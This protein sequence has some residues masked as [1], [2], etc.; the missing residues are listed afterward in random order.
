[1]E[2]EIGTDEQGKPFADKVTAVGGNPIPPPDPS[3]KKKKPAAKPAEE[4]DGAAA[5][6][7]STGESGDEGAKKGRNRK[8]TPKKEAPPKKSDWY[9]ELD[10]AVQKSIEAKGIKID[11]G[12]VFISVGDARLKVG[13]GG[14]ITLA[15]ASGLVA[16]G[17]YTSDKNGK[18]SVT[19]EK[20][21]KLDGAEW[22]ASSVD[23]G[24][25]AL[26]KEIDLTTGTFKS[27]GVVGV[28]VS[29]VGAIFSSHVPCIDLVKPTGEEE[30]PESLWGEGKPDPKDVLEKEGFLMRKVS[31]TAAATPGRRARPRNRKRGPKKGGKGAEAAPTPA[32]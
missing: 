16:E 25:G 19:W 13:T 26:L 29:L 15:H 2:F 28:C 32:S 20:V 7:E 22:K 3:R 24:N 1:M 5:K 27:I 30:K 4:G 21:L 10:E 18:L 12:R 14:Y 23:A 8:K 11:S 6:K 31:L 17:K 9:S